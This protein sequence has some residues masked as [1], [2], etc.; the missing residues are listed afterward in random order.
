MKKYLLFFIVPL[1]GAFHVFS[2]PFHESGLIQKVIPGIVD[3]AAIWGDYDGDG[4]FDILATGETGSGLVSEI[5][6]NDGNDNFTPINAGFIALSKSFASFADFDNDN[7]LDVLLCGVEDANFPDDPVTLLYENMGNGLFSVLPAGFDGVA[8]GF[9]DW[10][11]YDG[12]GDPDLLL[13]GNQGLFGRCRIYCNEG[14]GVF[15]ETEIFMEQIL[16]GEASWGDYDNDGDPDILMCG[17]YKNQ[18][19]QIEKIS[20]IYRNDGA[21]QFT[22]ID[23]GLDDIDNC[24]VTWADYDADGDLDI[25]IN[26]S[27]YGPTH[28]VY[29]FQNLGADTFF[30]I[31]IEIFGTVDGSISWG[32]YD[33]DGDLDFLIN[34]KISIGDEIITEVYKNINFGLFTK[35]DQINLLPLYRSSSAWADYD[36]DGDLDLLMTGNKEFDGDKKLTVL[37]KNMNPLVNAAPQP[38]S[39]L[40]STVDQNT[41]LLQWDRGSDIETPQLNLTYNIRLGSSPGTGDIISPLTAENNVRQLAG[42]G[43]KFQSLYTAV[44]DLSAGT[45]YWSVQSIDNNFDVSPFAPEQTFTITSQTG[46][47]DFSA[48]F[49]GIFCFPNPFH[50][51]IKFTGMQKFSVID[52]FNKDGTL[53]SR[54][55]GI[56]SWTW[57]GSNINGEKQKPGI[58][59]WKCQGCKNK[60][61][62]I[63]FLGN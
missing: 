27:T 28:M 20:V 8:N 7:D 40:S 50:D 6:R 52:V 32:D 13:S 60:E 9:S 54:L 3:G 37:Y 59:F 56:N 38:P 15:L 39:T 48:G 25:L 2:Q 31:G 33:N 19:G 53:I 45:Y 46:E 11:D 51:Q 5:F 17:N 4:D 29:I 10:A 1:F 58:Y 57:D 12:D 61:G 63:V 26:G 22:R 42:M 35:D 16:T 44:S 49:T 62:K 34:G 41:V 14:Q 24:N 55:T 23:P 18:Q 30:T 47:T 21:A 43:N 36:R